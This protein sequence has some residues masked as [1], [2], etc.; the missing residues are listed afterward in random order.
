VDIVLSQGW[1]IQL[2]VDNKQAGDAI[3][4]ISFVVEKFYPDS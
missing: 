1:T 4:A 2:T 3:T